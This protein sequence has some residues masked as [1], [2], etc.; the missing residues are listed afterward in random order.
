MKAERKPKLTRL[1]KSETDYVWVSPGTE[2]AKK[3]EYVPG[4]GVCV[5]GNKIYAD[6]FGFV[7]IDKKKVIRVVPLAGG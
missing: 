4:E 5:R 6:S 3:G 7:N 2:L 1:P